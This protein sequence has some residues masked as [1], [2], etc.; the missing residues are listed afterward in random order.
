MRSVRRA[1]VSGL[2]AA[3]L[4]PLPA[5]AGSQSS[6]SSSN[7]SDGHCT[8]VESF[9]TEDRRG[10]AGWTRV[11]QWH[12]R[13]PAWRYDQGQA[14]R[15]DYRLYVPWWHAPRRWQRDDDDD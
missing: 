10:R 8:R 11:E 5:L 7:C 2:L 4:A 3:W 14:W 15:H 12:E 6:N 13:A 1:A 9:V